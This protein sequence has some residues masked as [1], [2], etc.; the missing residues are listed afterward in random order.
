M[1]GP[2]SPL[3]APST[4]PKGLQVE[5]DAARCPHGLGLEDDPTREAP[6]RG[7]PEKR[8]H[9]RRHQAANGDPAE[10]SGARTRGS[11]TRPAVGSAP[12]VRGQT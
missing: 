1:E 7:I 8:Q 3:T 2:G 5:V 12:G 6:S 4:R 9:Q 10:S 11:P